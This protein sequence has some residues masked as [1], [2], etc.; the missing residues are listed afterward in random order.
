MRHTPI[1]FAS[2]AFHSCGNDSCAVVNVLSLSS[3]TYIVRYEAILLQHTD[4]ALQYA[5]MGQAIARITG[6]EYIDVPRIFLTSTIRA[7]DFDPYLRV[8]LQSF[9]FDEFEYFSALRSRY[10]GLQI[11][12]QFNT[13]LNIMSLMN[14]RWCKIG[15]RKTNHLTHGQ[16]IIVCTEI[17]DGSR[18]K[19]IQLIREVCSYPVD[20]F[21][22]RNDL[23]LFVCLVKLTTNTARD[24]LVDLQEDE[25]CTQTSVDSGLPCPPQIDQYL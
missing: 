11:V 9:Q 5:C 13:D 22:P 10:A 21:E 8:D 4:Q 14:L 23:R 16:A 18:T 7:H 2:K 6:D 17:L 19:S 15:P 20:V 24:K 1:H 12:V 3:Y 25:L